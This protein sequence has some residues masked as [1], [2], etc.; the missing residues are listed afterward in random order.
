MGRASGT[1]ITR[2]MTLVHDARHDKAPRTATSPPTK[3]GTKERAAAFQA[4]REA[5]D[6][7]YAERAL[8]LQRRT[9]AKHAAAAARKASAPTTRRKNLPLPRQS[10]TQD[11]RD[12]RPEV[13]RFGR[14]SAL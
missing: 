5:M 8:A 7:A 2:C 11:P 13:D 10:V 1:L 9:L 6:A 3:A 14:L 12:Y 4:K